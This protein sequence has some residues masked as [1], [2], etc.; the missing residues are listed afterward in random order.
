[1][2]SFLVGD[3]GGTN[4]RFQFWTVDSAGKEKI[5]TWKEKNEYLQKKPFGAVIVFF[6]KH[7]CKCTKG[8]WPAA[9]VLSMAGPVDN[10]W[11]QLTNLPK[12]GKLDGKELSVLTRIPWFQLINDFVAVG[13]GVTALNLNN[14]KDV[15]VLRDKPRREGAPIAVLGAGTGLG[16]TFLTRPPSFAE[17]GLE[18]SQSDKKPEY[19]PHPSE[20]GHTEWAAKN[21]F[22][23]R[24][25]KFVKEKIVEHNLE[26]AKKDLHEKGIPIYYDNPKFDVKKTRISTERIVCGWGSLV[27]YQFLVKEAIRVGRSDL[28]S[29][30]LEGELRKA[31]RGRQPMLIT[32]WSY[33]RN[34]SS[35]QYNALAHQAMNLFMQYYGSEAG[36][37]SLK[38]LPYGGLF[39]AGGIASRNKDHMMHENQFLKA[40]MNKGRLSEKI[41]NVPIYIIQDADNIGLLGARVLCVRALRE[42]KALSSDYVVQTTVPKEMRQ[43]SIRSTDK[44]LFDTFHVKLHSSL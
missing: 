38:T 26:E 15:F 40:F 2:K 5:I 20:G 28:V 10:N 13:Y 8:N 37:L 44:K 4:S 32:D 9:A 11:V 21:D 34:Q 27:V 39:V 25:A 35:G 42:Q 14:S 33:P 19:F 36:D 16:E 17:L 18:S 43:E 22:E 6:L 7:I 1:M 3:I 30:K 29:A 23:Y 24:L 31:D 41:E 12:W